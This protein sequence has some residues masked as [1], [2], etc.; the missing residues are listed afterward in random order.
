MIFELF[1]YS[2]FFLASVFGTTL[3]LYLLLFQKRWF[4]LFILALTLFTAIDV[5]INIWGT[6]LYRGTS[7][8]F[9]IAAN[10]III[11]TLAFYT[12]L[13]KVRVKSLRWPPGSTLY[14][15][16]FVFSI[17]SLVNSDSLLFSSYELF[18]L[19]RMY[20]YFYFLYQYITSPERIM[21]VL[22]GF[23][24]V[25]MLNLSLM[26]KQRYLDHLFQVHGL[27]PHQNSAVMYLNL[28][29]GIFFAYLLNAQD[30][31]VSRT[32][33]MSLTFLM[34]FL[35]TLLT[36][37]RGGIVSM[38][39][40]LGFIFALSLL[41]QHR[42]TLRKLVLFTILFLGVIG[43]SFKAG[44]TIIERYRSAPVESGQ[45]RVELAQAALNMV[46]DKKLGIGLNNFTLKANSPKY[47]YADHIILYESMTNGIVE[48][49]YLLTA[50]EC[51]WHTLIV[52]LLFLGLFL[53]KAIRIF[54]QSK[55]PFISALALGIAG[56]LIAIY[57]ESLFEWV[58]RQT[59]NNY[60]LMLVFA[61]VLALERLMK[62]SKTQF[63]DQ[64]A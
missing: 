52:Y 19:L 64:A 62:K 45:Y 33:W 48:T 21:W 58:L 11:L 25:V 57:F 49:S 54:W 29:N 13:S 36:L 42:L 31:N 27:F 34:G 39:L 35:S 59:S 63:M 37:S 3:G 4:F 15:F 46:Q 56:G 50:A 5:D 20:L 53:I 28:I 51:G 22:R 12:F 26:L 17:L 38:I 10:D 55:D 1:K 30:K 2:G 7:R 41:P 47:T 60:Q 6:E 18:K 32:L 24:V 9:E 43:I 40:C 14:L 23:S 61:L 44:N 8:G 16:Y